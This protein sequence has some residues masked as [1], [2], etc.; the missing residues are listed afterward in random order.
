MKSISY[1]ILFT[2]KSIKSAIRLI[3]SLETQNNITKEYI[4]Y[5]FFFLNE[6]KIRSRVDLKIIKSII[7]QFKFTLDK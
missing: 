2:K 4:N 6:N 5:K 3:V 7:T 1:N